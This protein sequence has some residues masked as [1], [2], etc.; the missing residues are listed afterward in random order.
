M[1]GLERYIPTVLW[2][3]GCGQ[4]DGRNSIIFVQWTKM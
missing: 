4:L 3:V 2:T 1:I